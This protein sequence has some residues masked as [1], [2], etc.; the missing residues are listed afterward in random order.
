MVEPEQQL[1]AGK[2]ALF[3]LL[4]LVVLVVIVS[5][6]YLGYVLKRS[7]TL[8]AYLRGAQRG[9][10]GRIHRADPE[11]GI[12]P[13]PNAR[14]SHTFPI[15]PPV[16]MRY[17]RHGF[18][19]T[20]ASDASASSGR[21]LVLAL[22]CSYTYGDA[23]L[24][25]DAFPYLV[26]RGLRG[27]AHNAGVCSYG[28]GQ[29]LILGR[30]LIPLRK[31]DYLLV[32]YSSWLIGRAVRPFAPSRFGTVPTP[33]FHGTNRLAL[34]RPVFRARILDLPVHRYRP[35]AGNRR[36]LWPFFWEVGLPFFSHDDLNMTRYVVRRI[37][38]SLPAPTSN[39]LLVVRHTYHALGRLARRHRVKMVVVM[40]GQDHRTP[41]SIRHLVPRD[42]LIVDA[43]AALLGRLPVRTKR[44]YYQAYG[45][46]RGKPPQLVDPH[47]NPLAHRVIAREILQRLGGPEGQIG[48][49][50][51]AGG[52]ASAGGKPPSK[53]DPKRE[54]KP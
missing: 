39:R 47:P 41:K 5:A 46:W 33:Y 3:R 35:P 54:S 49:L 29:M 9:W 24:A 12:A 50:K 13:I 42:V 34:Q 2:R 18:R 1:T 17:D 48:G 22:G 23:V 6:I 38:G 28:L 11:L 10:T 7:W 53:G 37:S 21:P 8:R 43:H 15:G 27:T 25:R 51:P 16:P 14:G 40:L 52:G 26:A 36:G 20:L 44:T 31:P 30:R 32:Q 4:T 19:G 45:H